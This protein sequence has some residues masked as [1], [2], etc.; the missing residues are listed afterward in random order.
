[1]VG[2]EQLMRGPGPVRG[3]PRG[4]GGPSLTGGLIRGVQRL[5]VNVRPLVGVKMMSRKVTTGQPED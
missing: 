5:S 4:Q 2:E 1:M 3:A